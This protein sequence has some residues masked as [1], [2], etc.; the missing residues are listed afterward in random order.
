MQNLIGMLGVG[1]EAEALDVAAMDRADH[2]VPIERETWLLEYEG[3]Q[4]VFVA[5]QNNVTLGWDTEKC[6][7]GE[8]LLESLREEFTLG[9]EHYEDEM[10]KISYFNGSVRK[11]AAPPP[12][13]F[14]T[15]TFTD[16]N[17]ANSFAML[18]PRPKCDL[19]V[20]DL[21]AQ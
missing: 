19:S 14:F 13:V 4:F 15:P 17:P 18:S 10:E 1:G 20:C 6:P 2:Q 8:G 12:S 11:K 21:S 3:S 7:L 16:N 9:C 5:G